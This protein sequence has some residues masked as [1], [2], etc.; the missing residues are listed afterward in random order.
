MMAANDTKCENGYFYLSKA[1]VIFFPCLLTR[2]R[3]FV[4]IGTK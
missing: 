2:G 1:A 3:E 4:K